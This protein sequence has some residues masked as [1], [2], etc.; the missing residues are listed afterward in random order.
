V[1]WE[2]PI[3]A[4]VTA[5]NPDAATIAKVVDALACAR[6]P[7]SLDRARLERQMRELALLHVAEQVGDQAYLTRLAHLRGELTSLDGPLRAGVSAERAVEWLGTLAETWQQADVP[8]AKAELLH[9]IYE[10][11]VV[12]GR[13]IVS[14][15][16]TPSAHQHGLALAMPEVVMA[17]PAGFGYA[18]TT[19]RI[20]IEGR[21]EWLAAARVRSA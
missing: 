2:A 8:E 1:T 7:V 14:A 10:R 9:A 18:L 20:P 16:L 15:R 4:Q 13:R 21:D 6:P 3:L 12:A 5:I 11:I 19:Y 17:S